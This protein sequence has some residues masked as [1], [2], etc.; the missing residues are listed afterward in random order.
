MFEVQTPFR[1]R[2]LGRGCVP[3]E[4]LLKGVPTFTVRTQ[5][6]LQFSWPS[7][8]ATGRLLDTGGFAKGDRISHR[9]PITTLADI[10]ADVDHW[11][12]AAYEL[13]A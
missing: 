8:K 5:G 7:S 6:L 11:L 10:D 9:I 3:G 4:C 12:Q 2:F 13:D 1:H